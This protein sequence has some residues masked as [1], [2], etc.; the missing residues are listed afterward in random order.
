M[1]VV[2]MA[3]SKIAMGHAFEVHLPVLPPTTVLEN[4]PPA[5]A[6][7]PEPESKKKPAPT[8][9][10]P[11][12]LPT[13]APQVRPVIVARLTTAKLLLPLPV[14]AHWVT[15][16]TRHLPLPTAPVVLHLAVPISAMLAM[17]E[18]VPLVHNCMSNTPAW[19]LPPAPVGKTASWVRGWA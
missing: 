9:A 4:P 18:M 6:V 7:P 10:V 8:T 13:P 1:Y 16:V 5:T 19:A 11:A 17:A 14:T 15:A 2:L 3:L 12:E